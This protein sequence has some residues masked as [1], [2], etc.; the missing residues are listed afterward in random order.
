MH[1]YIWDFFSG[2][3]SWCLALLTYTVFTVVGFDLDHHCS[4]KN[5]IHITADITT[6]TKDTIIALYRKYPTPFVHF[7]PPC[8]NITNIKNSVHTR[9][10]VSAF[11]TLNATKR[12]IDILLKLN[13]N[14]KFTI[15]NPDN[16]YFR[17][18]LDTNNIDYVVTHYCQYNEQLTVDNYTF[19]T[20]PYQKR[21]IIASNIQNLK[22]RKCNSKSCPMCID[23]KHI[24]TI[25]FTT[26]NE[27]HNTANEN[28]RML[29]Q[30]GIHT[31]MSSTDYL[32][33]VPPMLLLD[34]LTQALEL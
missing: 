30:H 25:H 14:L 8:E 15:E 1:K 33:R 11:A 20:F 5:G 16:P 18:W 10:L 22:L 3:G 29:K 34:I 12:V 7:S 27:Q 23:N 26:V 31:N 2:T 21:T 28:L 9:D 4:N 19:N 17:Q 32:H 6:L 24:T 13:P